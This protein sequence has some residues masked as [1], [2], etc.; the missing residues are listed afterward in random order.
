MVLN[1]AICD[2]DK[3]YLDQLSDFFSRAGTELDIRFRIHKFKTGESI[4]KYCQ[5]H[6]KCIDI[7]IMDIELGDG[8]NGVLAA[9]LI[10]RIPEKDMLIIFLTSHQD[11]MSRSFEVYPTDYISKPLM[12][13]EFFKRIRKIIDYYFN[14]EAFCSIQC[15]DGETVLLRPMKIL[16]FVT[17]PS[18]G[19]RSILQVL[20]E[21]KEYS[22]KAKFKD[23]FAVCEPYDFFEVHRGIAVNL[24]HIKKF[25]RDGIEMR[26]G[27]VFLIG[28]TKAESFKARYSEYIINGPRRP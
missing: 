23:L 24:Q 14:K 21:D 19:G 1:V 6:P 27:E 16:Y 11:Y 2:D 18:F 28:R 20:T 13:T 25:P 4:A 15:T 9:D 22:A 5:E 3:M 12:Y 8:I 17:T 7:A 10:R 26:D